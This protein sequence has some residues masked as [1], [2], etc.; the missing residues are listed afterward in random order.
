VHPRIPDQGYGTRGPGITVLPD[1]VGGS[2]VG[3]GRRQ[4]EVRAV[5]SGP[6]RSAHGGRHRP[7]GSAVLQPVQHPAEPL[8][9]LPPLHTEPGELFASIPHGHP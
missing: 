5:A 9:A 8:V 7:G 3:E 2:V 4:E 6:P 1:H